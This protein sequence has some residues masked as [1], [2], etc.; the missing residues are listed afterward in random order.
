MSGG[1]IPIGLVDAIFEGNAVDS[2][3]FTANLASIAGNLMILETFLDNVPRFSCFDFGLSTCAFGL[4]DL[5]LENTTSF[6]DDDFL[7]LTFPVANDKKTNNN[8]SLNHV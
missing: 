2:T 1:G 4:F 6:D 7:L 3:Y 8:T 5:R